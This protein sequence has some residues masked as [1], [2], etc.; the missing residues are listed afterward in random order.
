MAQ[1]KSKVKAKGS[2][3]PKSNKEMSQKELI[4]S[5]ATGPENFQVATKGGGGNYTPP[6]KGVTLGRF[7]S[8]VEV[9]LQKQ[10]PYQGKKK[11]PADMTH[12]TFEL[13]K[14]KN[15]RKVEVNG[16]E[17]E[18]TDKI[19]VKLPKSASDK[20]GYYKLFNRMRN[21][22]QDIIH[23]AQMLGEGFIIKVVHKEEEK[24]GKKII[25][26]GIRDPDNNGSYFV[27]PP[28]KTDPE[29][30]DAKPVKVKVPP[31]REPLKVFIWNKPTL[32]TWDSLFI[33]GQRE[34]E[35]NGKK[36]KVSKNYLQE[37]IIAAENFPHSPLYD[38][39]EG[40]GTLP[41]IEDLADEEDE[42][43]DGEEESDEDEDESEEY[44]DTDTDEDEEEDADD[45]DD[46]DDE[47]DSEEDDSEEDEEDEDDSSE[48]DD[49]SD[50]S[51]DD[52]DDEDSDDELDDED[53][54]EDE[55]EEEEEE[56]EEKP[57]PKKAKAKAKTPA[58]ATP[59]KKSV[60]ASA[61]KTVAKKSSKDKS[62][63]KAAK[64][65]SPSKGKDAMAILG[66]KK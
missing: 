23:P 32:A 46:S 14:D 29:D 56:E 61:S 58:K 65:K 42:E 25:Y 19:T 17:V 54:E 66:L 12:W 62:G 55:E 27:D 26:A 63:A 52:S 35:E 20:A 11:P 34:Y 33:D 41:D 31:A 36:V 64:T 1:V 28:Y 50:A 13:L 21:E 10:R 15:I 49:D 30:D 18:I 6:A 47:E 57:A 16:K 2:A 39:L 24:E 8:Y 45:A 60:T 59:A 38:L 37:M 53:E 9:G 22:R 44:E 5:L 4:E 48:D 3:K 7:I 40:N 51:D 43:E